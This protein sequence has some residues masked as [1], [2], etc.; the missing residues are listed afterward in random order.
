MLIP[1]VM[2]PI[3]RHPRNVPAMV[4]T[5]PSRLVPPRTTAVITVNSSPSPASGCAE[6]ALPTVRIVAIPQRNPVIT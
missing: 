4:P 3:K 5:P 6:L 1:R 2:V